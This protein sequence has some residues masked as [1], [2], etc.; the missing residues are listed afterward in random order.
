M[1]SEELIKLA[2]RKQVPPPGHYNANVKRKILLG[3][4]D[5]SE[6]RPAFID[7]AINQSMAA[8]SSK[9]EDLAAWKASHRRSF[10]LKIAPEGK[11]VLNLKKSK[12]P[13]CGSYYKDS[14]D[15]LTRPKSFDVFVSKTPKQT[16]SDVFTKL[17]KFVP[18]PG[19][20]KIE[21]K[22]FDFVS[23]SPYTLKARRH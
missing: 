18:S 12:D 1:V 23:R 9:Y 4:S 15:K 19:T 13:D 10:A 3:S 21:T 6:K 16:F 17:K 14:I 11:K 22:T 5:K 8:P 2:K 20:Y 7:L